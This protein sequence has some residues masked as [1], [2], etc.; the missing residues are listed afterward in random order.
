MYKYFLFTIHEFVNEIIM[1]IQYSWSLKAIVSFTCAL[2]RRR[3][4]FIPSCS[5]S[6]LKFVEFALDETKRHTHLI[7]SP[8]QEKFSFM[9]SKDVK[10]SLS[11]LSFE[12]TKI[13][14]LRRLIIE[15]ETMQV[16]FLMPINYQIDI[17]LVSTSV[18]TKYAFV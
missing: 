16:V 1:K 17:W 3:S 8:L 5:V 4:N 12:A 10:G 15:T 7:P 18:L 14:L 9:N 13:R 6:Y 2:R 11:M